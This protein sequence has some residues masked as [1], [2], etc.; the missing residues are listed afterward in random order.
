[1]PNMPPEN[2]TVMPI[3]IVGMGG[4]L[5]GEADNLEKLFSM[6]SKGQDAWSSIPS[7]RFNQAAFYHP[8]SSR[9]GAVSKQCDIMRTIFR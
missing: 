4:R 3:A 1:M 2:E 7:T 5:P 6:C 9:N 8:D